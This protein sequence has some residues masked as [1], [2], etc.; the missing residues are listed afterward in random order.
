LY[1]ITKLSA[2]EIGS[3]YAML[4]GFKVVHLRLSNVFGP[5]ER[6]TA[7]R[8]D[9]SVPCR[10]VEAALAQRPVTMSRRS[11]EAGRDYLSVTDAAAAITQVLTADIPPGSAL[12][13]ASGSATETGFLVSALCELVPEVSVT[14]VD[15]PGE[16]DIDV[17][18][19]LTRGRFAPYSIARL[20]NHIDWTPGSL[21]GELA[22]YVAWARGEEHPHRTP[23]DRTDATAG[24]HP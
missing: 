11:W 9:L 17:D 1:G 10:L 2:E 15:D 22:R 12:N 23:H 4:F 3:R 13:V 21:R 20:R 19:A 16:A 5:L 24:G 8:A 7:S 14:L 18:P 6:R